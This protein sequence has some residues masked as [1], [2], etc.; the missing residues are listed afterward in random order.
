MLHY[1][2][3]TALGGCGI[4]SG[5]PRM[6][7]TNYQHPVCVQLTVAR[8]I[9][10]RSAHWTRDMYETWLVRLA[11]D[12][13]RPRS[14][15][16]LPLWRLSVLAEGEFSKEPTAWPIPSNSTACR[17][18]HA[19]AQV[20]HSK[21]KEHPAQQEGTL[22][23]QERSNQRNWED[24]SFSNTRKVNNF[25]DWPPYFIFLS[26]VID[27][28]NGLACWSYGFLEDIFCC[29]TGISVNFFGSRVEPHGHSPSMHFIFTWSNLGVV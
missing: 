18:L 5:R 27:F 7:K 19:A 15:I 23:L 11:Q 25:T 17:Q 12:D 4:N 22:M 10:E 6:Q 28:N 2:R 1:C 14:L 20:P 3:A 29:E 24:S 26:V 16:P 13:H 8:P 21:T 9:S